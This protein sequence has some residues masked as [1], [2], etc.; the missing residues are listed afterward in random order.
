[1]GNHVIGNFLISFLLDSIYVGVCD[2]EKHL[3][4]LQNCCMNANFDGIEL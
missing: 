1:M 3:H 2:L 4:L